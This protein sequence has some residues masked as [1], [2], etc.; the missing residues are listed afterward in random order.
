MIE[1]RDTRAALEK[2]IKDDRRSYRPIHVWRVCAEQC[3]SLCPSYR[4][5]M[6]GSVVVCYEKLTHIDKLKK[7]RNR[8]C[9]SGEIN[10]S[11]IVYLH[12]E[13]RSAW[14]IILCADKKD[15]M[16]FEFCNK[17]PKNFD[18]N[19]FRIISYREI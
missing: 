11:I 8:R 9:L 14:P 10:A 18:E 15:D 19:I 2:L 3:E 6:F 4:C 16:F 5:E 12:L 7:F 13:R 17:N 1:S